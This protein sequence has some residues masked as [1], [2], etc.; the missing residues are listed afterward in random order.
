MIHLLLLN[1]LDLLIL[2]LHRSSS[3]RSLCPLFSVE[4]DASA[5]GNSRD[6]L[7]GEQQHIIDADV[8]W[9]GGQLFLHLLLPLG[10][11]L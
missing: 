8:L 9:C 6:Q 1:L 10:A 4:W 5:E 3:S 7:N 2:W 11:S